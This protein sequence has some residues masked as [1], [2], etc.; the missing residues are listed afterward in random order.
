M[1]N[2]ARLFLWL[3]FVMILWLNY[4]AWMRDYG[5]K[6][7][8]APAA[9]KGVNNPAGATE[10][11]SLGTSVPQV[12]QSTAPAAAGAAPAAAAP[13]AAASGLD[14]TGASIAATAGVVRVVTDVLDLQISL[15]GGELLHADLLKFP[16]IKGQAERVRLFNR[17]SPQSTYVMQSGLIGPSGANRPTHLAN[18]TAPSTEYRLQ[19]GSDEM[20][21][22]LSWTDGQGVTVTKTYV[23]KRSRYRINLEYSVD[24]RS[25]AP[26][27]A[28]SYAQILRWDPPVETSMFKVESYA[29]RGP[30]V[31]DGTK[32]SKLKIDD[33]EDR[34]RQ[35]DVQGGWIA[36]LQH[37]FVSAFVPNAEAK[38]TLRLQAI[39]RE[40][41]LSGVGPLKTVAPRTT[42]T[43]TEALFVGPKL[44][45]ELK[46]TGPRLDLVADYGMLTVIAD[47]LFWLL[48]KAHKFVGNW[49]LA[50]IFVTFLL[51][52]LFYPLSEAS[53]KS[54]AKMR[55][56]APRIKNLQET[57]KDDRE[58]LGQAMMEM[59]RR[60]KVNP[61]SG[62]LPML[63]QMP[64]FIAFY[65]VLLESVE[66]R[67]AP[68]FGWIND[69]SSRD[70]FFI[71]PALNGVAMFLQYKL[72][73]APAD[74]IQAKVF[75][76]MPIIFSIMFALFPAGLVLYWLTNTALSI[77][78]QWNIN[79]RIEAAAKKT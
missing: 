75:Q 49:G 22:P 19:P 65:W 67:Q 46:A 10:S 5:P 13:A 45:T 12:A 39:G 26:W 52:L 6:P 29:F 55:T 66:M 77:A 17:D 36:G 32:Y 73:P 62:C 70:P 79:R 50:I 9:V 56:L 21:L 40:Y 57:Y 64:V 33:E 59:Y 63:V 48:E 7:A 47:P 69:L 14:S 51:K 25:A 60:E 28:A 42:G 37:H 20:R 4:D 76:F 27:S 53:G 71:L 11:N 30:A 2:N 24:N 23:F 18:F 16:V 35:L 8:A 15:V 54:M 74:P 38:Y 78:Q 68:F 3:G 58:K 61:V 41:L 72:N 34:A 31:Y 43:F 1:N 44:Q